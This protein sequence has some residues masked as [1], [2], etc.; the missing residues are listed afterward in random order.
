M[1]CGQK[2]QEQTIQFNQPG[3]AYTTTPVNPVHRNPYVM[4]EYT[5]HRGLTVKGPVSG[6]IYRWN[7][8]GDRIPVDDR[9]ASAMNGVPNL[10]KVIH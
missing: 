10:K 5:G 4:M 3:T 1:C 8:T 6:M 2:R 7:V 9:D